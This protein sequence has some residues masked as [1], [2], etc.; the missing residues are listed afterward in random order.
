MIAAKLASEM[1]RLTLGIGVID[2]I[3]L[4]DV[5]TNDPVGGFENRLFVRLRPRRNGAKHD[6]PRPGMRLVGDLVHGKELAG[7][8]MEAI[9]AAQLG[10]GLVRVAGQ[11]S[12]VGKA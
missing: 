2:R 3:E 11:D 8:V 5:E 9:M 12:F 6:S 1:L 10:V 4:Y 7:R